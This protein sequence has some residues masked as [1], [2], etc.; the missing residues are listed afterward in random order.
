M[1][2]IYKEH[3]VVMFATEDKSNILLWEIRGNLEYYKE[4][5]ETREGKSGKNQHL[6]FTSDEEIKEGDAIYSPISKRVFKSV[7]GSYLKQVENPIDKKIVASNDP[8]IKTITGIVGS[9]LGEPLPQIPKSFIE[10]YC[11]NPVDKVELEYDRYQEFAPKGE[12]D[13]LA[14]KYKLKLTD[15]EVS[16]K[17]STEPTYT[18]D[19]VIHALT[20]GHVM[21]K[22]GLSYDKVLT[23]YKLDHLKE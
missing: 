19:D 15:N 2:T 18:R 12:I 5:V 23:A 13:S 10:S 8:E 4:R 17:P 14:Y 7:D 22:V 16:I 11:K 9:G 3:G 20:L 6:Y 1:E 21:G